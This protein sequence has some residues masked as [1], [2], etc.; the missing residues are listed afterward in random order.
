M[1]KSDENKTEN[2]TIINGVILTEKAI[3]RLKDFQDHNNEMLEN[4]SRVLADAVCLIA[5]HYD[6]IS[7]DERAAVDYL[8]FEL[9]FVRENINELV[10]P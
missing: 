1:K 6:D 7:A 4:V 9:T 8:M 5:R 3:N 10:R 2:C